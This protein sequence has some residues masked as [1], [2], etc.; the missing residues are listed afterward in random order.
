VLYALL[1]K[2][3]IEHERYLFPCQVLRYTPRLWYECTMTEIKRAVERIVKKHGG[4]NKAGRAV[5]IDPPY[6]SRLRTGKKINP[7]AN[8]LKRLGIE[9]RIVYRNAQ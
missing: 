8:I 3:A 5:G 9:R 2:S 4:L 1:S 7:S 6:L